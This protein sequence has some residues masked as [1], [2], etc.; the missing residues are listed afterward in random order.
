M[1]RSLAVTHLVM[2]LLTAAC[3]EHTPGEP[4][5]SPFTENGALVTASVEAASAAPGGEISVRF[6]NSSAVTYSTNVCNRR[7]EQRQ[8][9]SWVA[10]AEALPVCASTFALVS[11]ESAV[12]RNTPLPTGA[13]AGEFRFVFSM[14]P[15]IGSA[16]D[17]RTQAFRV[18]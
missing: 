9:D 13:T 1:R 12:S 16:T 10:F 15:G 7:V 18:E 17:V 5:V 8:G 4:A 2:P 6:V 11:P 14:Q 3:L